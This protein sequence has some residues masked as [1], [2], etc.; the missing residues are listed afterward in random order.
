M[1]HWLVAY[2]FIGI[3]YFIEWQEFQ[4]KDESNAPWTQ[5]TENLGKNKKYIN[6][7]SFGLSKNAVMLENLFS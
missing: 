1:K 2:S 6:Q 7:K 3:T 4:N 5:V